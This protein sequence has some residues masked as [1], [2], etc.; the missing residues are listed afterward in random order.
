[1]VRNN[2]SL[3]TVAS[4]CHDTYFKIQTK[5]TKPGTVGKVEWDIFR[6]RIQLSS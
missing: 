1:M 6:A 3:I 5:D 4:K 2:I